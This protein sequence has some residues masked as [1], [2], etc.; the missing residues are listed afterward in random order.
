MAQNNGLYSPYMDALANPESIPRMHGETVEQAL[1]RVQGWQ[2]ELDNRVRARADTAGKQAPEQINWQQTPNELIKSLGAVLSDADLGNSQQ[3]FIASLPKVTQT[4]QA[5]QTPQAS[6]GSAAQAPI[7]SAGPGWSPYDTSNFLTPGLAAV[8]TRPTTGTGTGSGPRVTNVT[9]A[10][11]GMLGAGN[12]NYNSALIRS[13]R[14]SSVTP[15]S[16]NPGVNFYANQGNT[17]SNWTPPAGQGSAFSPQVF[18]QRAATPQEINDYNAYSAYRSS[19]V[20]ASS[21]YLSLTDWIAAGRPTGVNSS[22]FSEIF[23]RNTSGT[24]QD[25]VDT[26]IYGD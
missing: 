2:N 15:F 5:T 3:A 23:G 12:A 17:Q 22:P 21:P 11:Q 8:Q 13:L 16:S 9:P 26:P 19:S 1:A 7:F 14:Q 25:N 20:G 10:A 6:Q 18:N 4:A 24:N